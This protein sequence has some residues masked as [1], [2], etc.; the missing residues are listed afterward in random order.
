[1][2]RCEGSEAMV[3]EAGERAKGEVADLGGDAG[4]PNVGDGEILSCPE[5]YSQQRA[6]LDLDDDAT[7]VQAH[8]VRD[9]VEGRW[10]SV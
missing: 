8:A 1:M 7:M 3:A 10:L 2:L 6:G 9:A 5:S 4:Y